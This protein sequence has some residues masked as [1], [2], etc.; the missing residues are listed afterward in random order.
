M[1]RTMKKTGAKLLDRRGSASLFP[2][3]SNDSL[4]EDKSLD[5]EATL[6]EDA[7]ALEEGDGDGA[8]EGVVGGERLESTASG[9]GI[10]RDTLRLQSLV[11]LDPC[12]Y[13]EG[14]ARVR[15]WSGS[16]RSR[17]SMKRVEEVKNHLQ[18]PDI[19]IQ[20]INCAEL[21]VCYRRSDGQFESRNA[22]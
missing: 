19:T 7:V 9:E 6:K 4:A 5:L 18:D 14:S 11:P 12:L 8:D 21:Y 22:P 15:R 20:L 3:L 16:K 1:N 10:T 13:L 17:S 2:T